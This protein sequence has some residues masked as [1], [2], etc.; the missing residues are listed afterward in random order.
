[1]GSN[2]LGT[3]T[4]EEAST[5]VPAGTDTQTHLAALSGKKGSKKKDE[6]SNDEMA[7]KNT[8][9]TSE[10]LEVDETDE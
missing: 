4:R 10:F 3:E 7:A 1:M 6:N 5:G 8:D 2:E 9:C